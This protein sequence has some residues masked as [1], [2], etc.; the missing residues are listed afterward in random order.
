MHWG[1]QAQHAEWAGTAS[2]AA[3]RSFSFSLPNYSDRLPIFVENSV[4]PAPSL[5]AGSSAK[6]VISMKAK[7]SI[8]VFGL[9]LGVCVAAAALIAP[10]SLAAGSEKENP[11]P[12]DAKSVETGR[13]L[14]NANCADCHGAGGRGDG[15]MAHELKKEPTDLTDADSLASTDSGLFHS[16][17]RG[18]RP[19]PGFEKM[20]SADER[21]HIV[22]FV[23]T[24]GKQK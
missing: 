2:F 21:W 22:N 8:S 19:M 15:K 23:R 10:R 6:K 17:S 13:A 24:L 4:A 18:R 14:Y 11:F 9:S 3:K 12:G 16:I 20:L 1:F 5:I 7:R